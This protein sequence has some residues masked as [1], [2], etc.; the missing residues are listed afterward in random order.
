MEPTTDLQKFVERA[1]ENR[2]TISFEHAVDAVE[3]EKLFTAAY[4]TIRGIDASGFEPAAIFVP[5]KSSRLC[6]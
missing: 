4:R 3:S 1:R 2:L 5:T 6:G